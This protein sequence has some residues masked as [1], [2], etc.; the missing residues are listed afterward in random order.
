M[1][2][3]LIRSAAALSALFDIDIILP[4]TPADAP[5]WDTVV[6]P[7]CH[8][9]GTYMHYLTRKTLRCERCGGSGLRP[10]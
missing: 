4:P 8:G 1:K 2:R 10:V 5:A 9:I 6:C 3:L 7:K